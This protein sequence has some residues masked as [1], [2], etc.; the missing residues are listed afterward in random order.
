MNTPTEIQERCL[1]S[2]D[3]EIDDDDLFSHLP[4]QDPFDVK[5]DRLAAELAAL[6]TYCRKSRTGMAAELGWKKSRITSVLSGKQ[7]MTLKTLWEFCSHLGYDFDVV[8]RAFSEAEEVRQPWQK[9]TVVSASYHRF[10]TPQVQVLPCK[11]QT[12]SEVAK[13]L[14][15]GE[16]SSFYI[17]IMSEPIVSSGFIQHLGATEAQIPMNIPSQNFNIIINEKE[18]V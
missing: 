8:F 14:F 17:G 6:M 5:K 10:E 3:S 18:S 1:I 9:S 7:N 12:P 16:P 13:D 11:L 4:A 15:N 2:H